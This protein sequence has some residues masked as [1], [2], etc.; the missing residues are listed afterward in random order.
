VAA[1]FPE[2]NDYLD[3]ACEPR[4]NPNYPTSGEYRRRRVVDDGMLSHAISLVWNRWALKHGVD[5]NRFG[6]WLNIRPSVAN[7]ISGGGLNNGG[8]EMQTNASSPT[9]LS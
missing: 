1:E 2:L 5:R 6:A 7:H 9:W 3:Q 8:A 4:E